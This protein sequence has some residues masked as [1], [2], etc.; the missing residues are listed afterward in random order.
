M[1]IDWFVIFGKTYPYGLQ[2]FILSTFGLFYN[3]LILR[4][5]ERAV[6]DT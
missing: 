4:V 6:F 2:D 1:R 3:Q 5:V